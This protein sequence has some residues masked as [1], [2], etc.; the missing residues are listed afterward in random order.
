MYKKDVGNL[1]D[2]VQDTHAVNQYLLKHENSII[3]QLS[4][5]K[6][7]NRIGFCDGLNWDA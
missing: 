4:V 6:H 7:F 1:V 5:Q 3:H 2:Q